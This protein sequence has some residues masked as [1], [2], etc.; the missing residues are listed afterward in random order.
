MAV[1]INNIEI[2]EGELSVLIFLE[3]TGKFWDDGSTWGTDDHWPY[4]YQ[5][6]GTLGAELEYKPEF[7]EIEIGQV[8]GPVKAEWVGEEG[9][10]KVTMLETTLANLCISMGLDPQDAITGD[11]VTFGGEK[12][13][14]IM[15]L[16]Y[17]ISQA[18]DSSKKDLFE[19]FQVVPVGGATLPFQKGEERKWEVTF[20]M[21]AE[22]E[23][24]NRIGRLRRST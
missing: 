1:N 21:R 10:F 7:K 17:E 24:S 13:T 20:N 3:N 5:I 14:L 19:C 2:G 22:P 8:L 6:G 12:K 15:A 11:T 18:A 4:E 16:Q 9:S 23:Q